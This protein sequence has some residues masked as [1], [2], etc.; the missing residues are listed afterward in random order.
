LTEEVQVDIEKAP[1]ELKLES[2]VIVGCLEIMPQAGYTV[3]LNM[4][5]ATS[6]DLKSFLLAGFCMF[7]FKF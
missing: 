3:L 4:G 6:L 7:I 2:G 1:E 5:E